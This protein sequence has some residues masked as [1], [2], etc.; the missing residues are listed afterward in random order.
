[1]RRRLHPWHFISLWSRIFVAFCLLLSACTAQVAGIPADEHLA[2]ASKPSNTPQQVLSDLTSA[3]EKFQNHASAEASLQLGLVLKEAGDTAAAS[4]LL[5][6][7]VKMNPRLSQ[8]WY[9]RG[10]IASDQGDWSRAADFFRHTLAISPEDRS[11]HLELGEMLLRIGDFS[12][13]AAQLRSALQ[14]DSRSAGAHQ[15][16]GLIDLQEGKADEAGQEFRAALAIHP[17]YLD[18]KKGLARVFANQHRW[19]EAAELLKDV[20]TANPNSVEERSSLGTALS[21][22]GDKAG[23]AEQFSRAQEL[24]N[25]QV[26][27]LR[28]EGERNW[29][30]SLRNEGKLQEASAA[31]RR[32]LGEDSSYCDAHDD[33]GEVL[34]MQKNFSDALS[35]FRAAVECGSDS[36]SARN[37]LGSALLY[38]QHDVDGSIIQLRAATSA[39]PGFALAHFN[40]G[41][42][43]AAR[44][45]YASAEPEFRA[46]IAIDPTMAAA[47]LNL[48][49]VLAMKDN[50]LSTEAR[51]EIQSGLRLDPRLRDFVPQQY[52]AEL[53]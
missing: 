48:G 52:L 31:F 5:D 27:R 21:N 38:Y 18:A 13:A 35:E 43:L 42:A 37:N 6:E 51:A 33:L 22:L 44:Q 41:K 36:A 15:G 2:V 29:G 25:R 39:R 8:A 17:D 24:S 47:H 19:A 46:A 40:L 14:L 30:V 3:R 1:M 7:A 28:A 9:A 11:A 32:A 10:S 50:R 12:D 16:L 26:I 20:V 49:I 53:H 4:K 45:E 23:A 34:W